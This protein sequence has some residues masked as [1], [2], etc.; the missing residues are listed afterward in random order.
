MWVLFA[1]INLK[2]SRIKV[3]GRIRERCH[4]SNRFFTLFHD[5]VFL[6]SHTA[7]LSPFR[8]TGNGK[9]SSWTNVKDLYPWWGKRWTFSFTIWVIS[10]SEHLLS[11]FAD[12]LLIKKKAFCLR[13]CFIRY[14]L[15]TGFIK[16]IL[17]VR[18]GFGWALLFKRKEVN[19]F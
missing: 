18:I 12:Y 10:A 1:C 3:S 5:S 15:R 8:M 17:P 19:H 6:L 11:G 9:A 14:L 4:L 7:F 16:G 2:G 13:F